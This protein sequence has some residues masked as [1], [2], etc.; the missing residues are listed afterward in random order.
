MSTVNSRTPRDSTMN[1]RLNQSQRDL[2]DRAASCLGKNR[3]D[4][5]LETAYREAEQVL[6]DRAYITVGEET[7]NNFCQML[8]NPPQPSE[9]LSKL[10]QVKA[11]W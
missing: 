9:A 10:M 11:P 2:I 7:F 5:V 3:S 1:I 4:F 8:D 6:L